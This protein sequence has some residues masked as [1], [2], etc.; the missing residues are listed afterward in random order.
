MFLSDSLSL[1]TTVASW[2]TEKWWVWPEGKGLLVR[3]QPG[4]IEVAAMVVVVVAG[5]TNGELKLLKI[6]EHE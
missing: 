6:L 4:I 5:G 1:L 3:L 2:S